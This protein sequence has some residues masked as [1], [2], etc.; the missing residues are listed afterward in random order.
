MAKKPRNYRQEYDR[1]QGTPAQK[2]ARAKRNAARA[3]EMKLGHVH[4]GDGMDVNHKRGVAAG[5]SADNLNVMPASHNRSYPRDHHGGDTEI[6][7]TKSAH[8]VKHGVPRK[9]GKQ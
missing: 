5:N 8:K 4:K 3:K 7:H 2:K 1:Y 6:K 9:K